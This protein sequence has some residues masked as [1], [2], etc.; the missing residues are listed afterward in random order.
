MAQN[1]TDCAETAPRFLRLRASPSSSERGC[2][3]WIASS[4]REMDSACA[5]PAKSLGEA[6]RQ[7]KKQ[8]LETNRFPTKET[9]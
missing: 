8:F 1:E 7:A 5:T 9:Q 4:C 2:L 3:L 6:K